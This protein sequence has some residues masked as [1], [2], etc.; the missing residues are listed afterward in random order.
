MLVILS[1]TL[2]LGA[3]ALAFINPTVDYHNLMRMGYSVFYLFFLLIYERGTEKN[4]K[5]SSVKCWIV[6]ISAMAIISNQIVISNVSYHK[7]QIAYEKSYGVLVRIADRIEQTEGAENCDKVL[8]IGALSDSDAYSVNLTPD[9]TGVTDGYIIR[10]DD[11]TVRQ[12][13]LTSSLNDYCG[14]DYTFISGEEKKII[15]QKED[16][17]SMGIWPREDSV[18]IIDNIIVIKLGTEGEN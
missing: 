10:A 2:I 9:I 5:H 3:G 11:E 13:V 8:V 12:S 7:A 16:I 6:L 1:I 15:L 4:E 14:K 18:T 17:K